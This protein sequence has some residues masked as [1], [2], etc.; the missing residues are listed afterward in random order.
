MM[1]RKN[2][3]G[4]TTDEKNR[5]VNAFLALKAQDSVVHPGAQSRYDDFRRNAPARDA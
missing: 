4:L 3:K 5:F 1:C 2:V